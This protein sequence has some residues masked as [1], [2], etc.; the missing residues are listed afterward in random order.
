MNTCLV[1]GG[2]FFINGALR[3]SMGH[4]LGKQQLC[5]SG[6]QMLTNA[7]C[8]LAISDAQKVI[9]QCIKRQQSSLTAVSRS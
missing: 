6:Y 8:Q 7:R 2:A 5:V 4:L 9:R 3:L 1:K